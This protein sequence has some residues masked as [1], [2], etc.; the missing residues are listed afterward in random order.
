MADR[1]VMTEGSPAPGADELTTLPPENQ[2]VLEQR[3]RCLEDAVAMLQDTKRVEE[4]IV[5]RLSRRLKRDAPGSS[6]EP[7][8]VVV[9]AGR[10]LLPAALS[11][12]R[13][14]A[15][16]AEEASAGSPPPAPRSWLVF[17]AYTEA[18]AMA[19]MYVD[20]RYRLTWSAK[21]VPP[22]LLLAILTSWIWIPGTYLL[23]FALVA[24]VVKV[25]DLVLAFLAIKVL[26]REVR[27]YRES[28]HDFPIVPRS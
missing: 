9:D 14:Q 27:R 2:A 28:T 10:Q 23:P 21:V 12:I 25:V 6:K 18:R 1:G 11:F 17:E 3:V 20:P 24:V 5:E 19:R 22:V 8:G 13:T 16:N 15:D 26:I 7:A 4:R